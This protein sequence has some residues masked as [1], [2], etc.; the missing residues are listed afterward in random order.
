[1]AIY[2]KR[3]VKILSKIKKFS[4]NCRVKIELLFVAKGLQYQIHLLSISYDSNIIELQKKKR[5]WK[6]VGTH[7]LSA[8]FKKYCCFLCCCYG[9]IHTDFR[10]SHMEPP[11]LKRIHWISLIVK[12]AYLKTAFLQYTPRW[13]VSVCVKQKNSNISLSTCLALNC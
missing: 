3:F 9:I 2:R 6:A 4:K 8:S 5:T 12:M 10:S 1:M 13:Y 11:I 7:H